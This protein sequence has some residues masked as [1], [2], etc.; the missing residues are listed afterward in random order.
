[1]LDGLGRVVLA[2]R[3]A[4]AMAGRNDSFHLGADGIVALR[5]KDDAALRQLYALTPSEARLAER[6]MAG[7]TPERA[8]EALG[9]TVATV[10]TYLASIFRKTETN[11]QAELVRLLTA[12]PWWALTPDHR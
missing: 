6:L 12:P 7:D 4:R 1:M 11:R 9:V 5:P 3:A 8:A 10:R 2:N